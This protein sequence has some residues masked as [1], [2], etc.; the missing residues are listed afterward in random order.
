[1]A[2]LPIGTITFLFSDIEGSSKKWEQHPDAMRVA[3]AAHDGMLRS[4]FEAQG[5]YVFKTIGDAFCVAFDTAH[6]ALT[7]ALNAQ[8]ALHNA[9]WEGIEPLKVRMALHTGAA[10]HRDGDY[11]GQ[12]LNRVAR[13][14]ASAHGGQVL[15][16]LPT[17]ELV[18]DGLPPGVQL[19]ALG[20]HRLRDLARPEQ[21]FQL[22][23]SD[24]PSQFPALRS[25]ES[26]PNNLP[27]QLTSFIG[28]ERE[29]A[30]VKRLLGSSRLLTLTGS[31]GTG[32]TRLSL[33]VG[34]ELL[35]QFHDG[36]WFVEFG[37]VEDG[38]LVTEAVAAALDLRQ[39][40]ERSLV[41]TLGAFCRNRS[42]LLILDN[43]E[44]VVAACA[45]LAET[46]LRSCPHLRILA[47]S[48]EPLGIAGENAW[49]LPPLSLP[50]HWRD[51]ADGPDALERL[52]EYE[53]VRLFVDRATLARP[54]FQAKNENIAIITQICWRLDGIALAIELAAA[55]IRV[56]TL[57]QIVERLDD[58]F[59]LLTT[60]SRTAV[61]RQQ[62][63]R[64]L[65]DW[66][67]DL[68]SD[69]ERV[70][71][72]R[73]AVFARGRTLESIEAVCSGGELETWQIVDLVTQLV[74]KSLIYLEKGPF[75]DARYY[76][77]ES[78]WDYTNEKLV[79]AGEA[80]I[81]RVRHLDYFSAY[82]E[83]IGPQLRG[84]QQK[85]WLERAELE[86]VNFRFA[87]ETCVEVPGEL[88]K[89][90]R[91]MTAMQRYVEVRGLFK[92]A[93]EHYV[94]V[95]NH[96]DAAA[97]DAVRARGLAAAGRVAWVADDLPA[98]LALYTEAMEIFRELGDNRGVAQALA[99]LAFHALDTRDLPR[100]KE[101]LAQAKAL[102]A[103]LGDVRLTSHV[104]HIEGVI[105]A[106][107]GDFSRAYERAQESL[108]IYQQ[109]GDIWLAIIVDWNV[110]VNAA[111][112][113]N[114]AD[115]RTHLTRC[116]KTGLEL[117]NRWGTSYPLEALA[118]LAVAEQQYDRAARLFG[119]A[120]AHRSR[121]GLVPQAAEHPALR[122][123]LT[124]ATD[125]HG[126][127][128][129]NAR[130][131]GRFLSL[132]AAVGLALQV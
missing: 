98:T 112:L 73:L 9:T 17:E 94:K 4:T 127:A 54:G 106:A 117:G 22:V 23:T 29:L 125:F 1:M 123:I 76:M 32:K 114:F 128:I 49:P 88:L 66:S 85:E 55:R 35:D 121:A 91:L 37:T 46:L 50:N 69:P 95:L 48:R 68:L 33:Q 42:I 34:A 28:R 83:K 132:D 26:V 102:A 51:I 36:V 119:A 10:E 67:H 8:R 101:L 118:T 5:G 92:E 19:R 56:L 12:T 61:P 11:F 38:A 105:A 44:H 58:R 53:A 79:A 31:G 84:P 89:G 70:L 86:E 21:L 45:R 6:Q 131:E 13:I 96:P 126:S 24:L 47:S 82:A 16:S 15:L 97:R 40:P 122:A 62:T 60:G 129:E 41:T 3:L 52:M 78:I 14:L 107:E 30:E 18:R 25:L 130:R 93:R 103:P 116:L 43:C 27:M 90:L 74:D 2:I 115:A 57:Q 72:R 111:A 108:A 110:G 80:D 39:E 81:Y 109:I 65:I 63:L 87:V 71:L 59:H 120:E 113:G 7:G 99:D 124:A 100:A 20:E 77:L 64:S 75:K 104:N